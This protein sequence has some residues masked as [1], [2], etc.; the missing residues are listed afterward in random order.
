MIGLLNKHIFLASCYLLLFS[1]ASLPF[2]AN[3]DETKN[4]KNNL[5]IDD[6]LVESSISSSATDKRLQQQS[7]ELLDPVITLFSTEQ[8]SKMISVIS[9]EEKIRAPSTLTELINTTPSVSQNGQGGH[10]QNFSIRGLS[11]HRIK[12][13]V[14]RMRIESDRRA[15]VSA[16]FID[17]L[18][19]G[20]ALVWRSPAST[21]FGSGAL[22]GA[23][24]IESLGFT[25]F[26]AMTGYSSLGN[27]HYQ[28]LGMGYDNSSVGIARREAANTN[29]ADGT[30]LNTH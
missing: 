21:Y 12:T 10:F 25:S 24:E 15:G 30:E 2:A 16:S 9:P 17:P 3:G 28:V 4:T 8:E 27:E 29:A 23:V 20:D 14:N 1:S 5:A 18:L 7:I 6:Q 11:R 22:G 26:Q 13:V 19:I